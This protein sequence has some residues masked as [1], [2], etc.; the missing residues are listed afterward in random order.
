[1]PREASL[2]LAGLKAGAT[3]E[4]SRLI[5]EE[6]VRRFTELSGDK[7]S[8]HVEPDSS[9]RLMAHG[10]LTATLPTKLGGDLDF[11]ARSMR[12]E[13]LR[14]VY[15][16]DVLSCEG[17]VESVVAQR[18]RFKVRFAFEIVNQNGELVLKG[19]SAGQILRP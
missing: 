9:G 15:A 19:A 13:F 3:F 10:L 16:G 17:T 12:F 2:S 8:H 1:M 7:G 6:D 5:T 14:P 4:H 11:V 18:T